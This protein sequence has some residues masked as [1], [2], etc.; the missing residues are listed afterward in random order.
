LERETSLEGKLR[1]GYRFAVDSNDV[2]SKA[3]LTKFENLS[4]PT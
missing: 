1:I 2:S 3:K 4:A